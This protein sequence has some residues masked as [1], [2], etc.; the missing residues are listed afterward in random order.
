MPRPEPARGIRGSL[1]GIATSPFPLLAG[2]FPYDPSMEF[3]GRGSVAGSLPAWS[4]A[5]AFVVVVV[6]AAVLAGPATAAP[7]PG[8]TPRDPVVGDQVESS[9]GYW[10]RE[11]MLRAES[12][13]PPAGPEASFDLDSPLADDPPGAA[14][15]AADGDFLPSETAA[16]PLR[17]HGKVFLRIDG[18]DYACSGTVVDSKGKNVLFTAGHCVFDVESGLYAEQLV[19]VPA[20]RDGDTPY[21]IW[22]A[23]AVFTTARFAERGALSHDIGVVI[24]ERKIQLELGARRIAFGLNPEG[25]SYT[26]YGYPE[27]PEALYDGG[28]LVGCRSM[29]E[30][31]DPVQGSPAPIAAGPCL[32]GEGSSG[33]AWLTAGG[34]LN[35]VVSYGYCGNLP[36]LC[37]LTFGPYFSDQALD[38]YTF[39]A[40]GGSSAPTVRIK[41]GPPRRVTGR[42]AKFR[43][44]GSGST[45]VTFRC[46][47][48]GRPQFRCGKKTKLSRLDRGKYVLRVRSVDQTG[49]L[50]RKAAK[51]KFKVLRRGR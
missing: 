38:L 34:L 50:S 7:S 2:A 9:P 33:G 36:E 44:S 29:S 4:L 6:A 40:V 22:P 1:S 21:G 39:P 10:T 16:F 45:P 27:E 26:I 28:S 48:G 8:D 13:E 11:R 20:F 41:S 30:G 46:R 23:S 31:R 42:K 17:V 5:K 25:R 3:P 51:R 32:M 37:G 47:L 24:L 49:K 43:F 35:S 15:S 12:V 19:F 18:Q 14:A